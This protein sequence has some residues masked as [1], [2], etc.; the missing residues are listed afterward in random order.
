M[1]EDNKCRCGHNYA[2]HT[3]E[4]MENGKV[5]D[6]FHC[7]E[8]GK[9][10][11][12][13][14][15]CEVFCRVG[16]LTPEYRARIKAEDDAYNKAQDDA[17]KKAQD[18]ARKKA[19]DEARKKEK[20]RLEKEQKFKKEHEIQSLFH[21]CHI[22]NLS[23]IIEK[24]LFSR[25]RARLDDCKFVDIADQGISGRRDEHNEKLGLRLTTDDHLSLP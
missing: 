11:N 20:E 12:G 8:C 10:Q 19:Q 21:I 7:K 25:L 22:D 24:G 17:R 13:N 9:D 23:S 4:K 16:S 6:C 18:E 3:Y 5:C 15:K 2:A 14:F 1:S